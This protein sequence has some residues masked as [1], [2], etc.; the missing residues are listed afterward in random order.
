[1]TKKKPDPEAER[2]RLAKI[3]AE[4]SAK[5]R[6]FDGIPPIAN[7]RR[8]ARCRKSLRAFCETY[9]PAAFYLGWADFHRRAIERIEEAATLGALY[10][11]AFPRGSGKTTL[12]RMAALWVVANAIRRY[13]FIIGANDA[14]AGDTLDSLRMLIRFSP[15]FAA[16]YPEVSYPCQHLKGIGQRAGGQTCFGESTMVE[17]A[18]DRVVLATVPPPPNWPKTWDLRADG[19]VPTSGAV[20][21]ASGLTGEGIRGSLLTLSTGEM[22]RPDF[23][24]LDDPQT[25][26][27]AH[28]LT[29][30]TTREHLVGADVLGM[31]GPDKSIAAVMPCTVIAE[32]DFVDRILDREKHPLWRGERVGLLSS[33]PT[34]MTAWDDYFDVYR[35]CAQLEPPDFAAANEHYRTNREALDAG[36]VATWPDRKQAGD[37]SAVQ[38]AMHLYCRDR[39]AFWSEG[40]NRPEPPESAV[41]AKGFVAAELAKRVNGHARGSVPPGVTRLTAGVDVG[42]GLLWWVVVGWTEEFGG[43]VI[44]YGCHPR[45]PR[46]VFAAAEARPSLKDAFPG[47]TDAQRVFAGLRDVI[48]AVL[49]RGYHAVAGE[50][51]VERCLVD[52]GWEPDAVYQALAASP[53]AGVIYPSKGVGRSATQV[54][55]ARWKPR[56]GER[57]G[58][59]WRLTLGTGSGRG[60]QVQFDPD[61]WKSVAHGSAAIPEGG[62][63]GLTLFGND[64]QDHELFAEHCAAES[65]EPATLKGDTFDKWSIKPGRSDNHLLDALVLAYVAA[66]VQGLQL[67]ADGSANNTPAERKKVKLSDL[68]RNRH[69][70]GA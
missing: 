11:L 62:R 39:R 18:G 42:G 50:V 20:F 13:V 2:E 47:M 29:Q 56:P 70:Q 24:L 6:N 15:E 26:E 7:V 9:N 61:A 63:S 32:G 51:R 53:F 34:N 46:R 22:I 58:H 68:M 66:S 40:M 45:Q 35:A 69:T 28:S 31:A 17:W 54:G 25:N 21:S 38:A 5:G 33:M 1:M 65:S 57:A 64:P 30:N 52:A 3:A 49:G 23:V 4:R 14:K 19:K 41:G 36:A 44:D 60:R 12:C 37:V 55:V 67:K 59:H 16:D 10:A 27:S 48:P 43:R 8:R